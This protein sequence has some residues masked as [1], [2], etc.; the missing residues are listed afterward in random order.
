L[1]R[2]RWCP[3][4]RRRSSCRGDCRA[5]RRLFGRL[6]GASPCRSY[7]KF[8]GGRKL[9]ACSVHLNAGPLNA[10]DQLA[11][12]CIC[13]YLISDRGGS[14]ASRCEAATARLIA[15]EVIPRG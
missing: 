14:G 15:L 6:G 11:A 12:R 8:S 13:C 9:C 2:D 4:R 5:N 3:D 1:K 7:A 10:R